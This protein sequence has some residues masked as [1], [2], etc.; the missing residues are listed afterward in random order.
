M[1]HSVGFHL[2][3][4]EEEKTKPVT[5]QAIY[6]AVSWMLWINIININSMIFFGVF[7]ISVLRLLD[8]FIMKCIVH[9]MPHI[10]IPAW[11]HIYLMIS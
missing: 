4:A 10:R 5:T 2:L 6:S 1:F 9:I 7:F 8:W 3:H 11:L